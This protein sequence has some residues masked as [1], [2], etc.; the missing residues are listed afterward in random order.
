MRSE[1]HKA[2]S[3]FCGR[4]EEQSPDREIPW[5]E[6]RLIISRKIKK[7]E[8]TLPWEEPDSPAFS[9][10]GGRSVLSSQLTVSNLTRHYG[11]DE[12]LDIKMCNRYSFPCVYL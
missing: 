3:Q 8:L 5:S 9:K 10:G 6:A 2:G 4:S 12:Y 7:P 1:C 11:T